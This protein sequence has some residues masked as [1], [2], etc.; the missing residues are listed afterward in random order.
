MEL[1]E[2]SIT[3]KQFLSTFEFYNQQHICNKL[4]S[5]SKYIFL[6]DKNF[7]IIITEIKV[8]TNK[9]IDLFDFSYLI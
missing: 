4:L 3:P 1:P 8:T 7:N 2:Y 9:S 5:E 6:L